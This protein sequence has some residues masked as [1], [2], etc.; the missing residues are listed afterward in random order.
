MIQP[1]YAGEHAPLQRR[2]PDEFSSHTVTRW[3]FGTVR[4]V[5][6]A[7]TAVWLGLSLTGARLGF[8]VM[9][10]YVRASGIRQR[11]FKTPQS[12]SLAV[13]IAIGLAKALH[14]AHTR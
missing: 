2:K 9:S 5:C 4:S 6:I 1:G 8:A 13:I 11:M 12:A 7:L 3:E 14:V 10:V